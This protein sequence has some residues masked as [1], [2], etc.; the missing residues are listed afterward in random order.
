M[1]PIA[2][3]MD[4]GTSGIRAQAIDLERDRI[5]S[6][7]ITMRHPLPGA[8]VIDHLHFTL[9]MGSSIAQ[10]MLIKAIN[11][12]ID[13]LAIQA[14]AVRCLAV[15]GNPTQ[16]SIFQ[17]TDIRDLAYAGKRKL[18]SMGI[19]DQERDAVLTTADHIGGLSLPFD[20]QLII[21]PAIRHEVGA[22]ALAMIIQT[23]ML[24]HSRTALAMD[25]GTNA[26]MALVHD[27]RVI[28]ASTAAGPALE[29]QQISCGVLAVPGAIADV[30]PHQSYHRLTVLGND[31]RPCQGAVVDLGRPRMIED[32]SPLRPV[33]ITGTGT[34]AM[35][36]QA[37]QGHW[38][39]L[40]KIETI[41][42]RLHAGETITLTE[43]DV[44]EAGKAIGA[45]RAGQLSLCH[46][47]GISPA[48][49]QVAYLAGASGTY[50]DAV[51]AQQLGMLP[52]LVETIFQ[53]GN[54][55]LAM[56]RDLV[57]SPSSLPEMSA[58]ANQLRDSHC[59]LATSKAFQKVYLLEISHWTEGM[60][61]TMY[62][63]MLK[64]YGLPDF[65]DANP[66]DDIQ[67]LMDCDILDVGQ[68]G[69]TMLEDFGMTLC[70]AVDGCTACGQCLSACTENAISLKT[71]D[72]FVS[73]M[74]NA[75][76]C[77]GVNCK[78]CE[79]ACPDRVLDWQHI[80]S[81]NSSECL[82]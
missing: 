81:D 61:M 32:A 69:L 72:D 16:L 44:Q 30:T 70:V 17:G 59:M 48:D 47:A 55:S 45:L 78:R 57:R 51:K 49:I 52:P 76:I 67:R 20:C 82:K 24:N 56:A 41:D 54:T 38:L 22:D 9:E 1:N 35:I 60:P 10:S 26:E 23:G 33:G 6:T 65:P 80:F 68:K 36:H 31:M 21:P 43:N 3:A 27:G 15:C 18:A 71:E 19:A 5:I 75:S 2:I 58:L 14:T 13:A 62:R 40:P 42:G 4:I 12:V 46:E 74:I 37:L 7:V 50:V 79:R 29:G 25:F 66:P 77:S 53:V 34:I 8:N 39:V 11:Q 28:T 63:K 73:I 64:R